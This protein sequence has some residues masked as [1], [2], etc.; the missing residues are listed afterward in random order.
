MKNEYVPLE[1]LI[2]CW[3]AISSSYMYQSLWHRSNQFF[4]IFRFD[5]PSLFQNN[6]FE[7][8]LA[9]RPNDPVDFRLHSS[10]G[11]EEVSQ[12]NVGSCK[13]TIGEHFQF[14]VLDHNLDSR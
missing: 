7:V 11:I 1:Q 14:Y 10:L 9:N 4:T 2:L 12:L 13:L 3:E 5:F 6:P 8:F